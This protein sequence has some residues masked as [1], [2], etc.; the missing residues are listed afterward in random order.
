MRIPLPKSIALLPALLPMAALAADPKSM[1]A[2]VMAGN[3][4]TG[5]LLQTTFGLLLVLALIAVAAW[6][7]KRFGHYQVAV[8]GKMKIVGGVSLGARERV[9]LLQVGDNQLVLGVAPGQIRTLHVLEQPLPL[10]GEAGAEAPSFATRLQTAL[11]GGRK[12]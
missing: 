3:D 1:T 2:P 8:Q 12:P 7:I 9:V 6:L 11:K 10:E 5:N 4:M